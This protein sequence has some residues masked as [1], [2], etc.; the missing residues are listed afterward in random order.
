M[1]SFGSNAL[2]QLGRH[3]ASIDTGTPGVHP[4][5]LLPGG[6]R[7]S[8]IS[9]GLAHSV[10]AGQLSGGGGRG[11][12]EP[13][14][15]LGEEGGGGGGGGREGLRKGGGGGAGGEGGLG[16][17]QVSGAGARRAVFAWG[18]NLGGHLGV[19]DCGATVGSRGALRASTSGAVGEVRE[20]RE[21]E[22]L[23][24]LR[25]TKVGC[26]RVHSAAVVEDT[27]ETE[28]GGSGDATWRDTE[29]KL[30]GAVEEERTN[31]EAQGLASGLAKPRVEGGMERESEGR[32][33]GGEG[34]G[35]GGPRVLLTWGAGAN[36]R[37]GLGS[38][39]DEGSPV[40]V[41]ALEGYEVVQV[42][43]GLDHTLVLAQPRL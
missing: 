37:L 39:R 9:A 40:L 8:C 35:E 12:R 42:S 43:C 14:S 21:V 38:T 22:D 17:S 20:P 19:G 11:G 4:W 26:G 7:A 10:V 30:E 41:E 3:P 28:E 24:G 34:E 25:V 27:E 1:L 23:R 5:V 13:P 29:T 32:G 15:R 16:T 33:G 2:G 36:G 18:M 6:F 31:R